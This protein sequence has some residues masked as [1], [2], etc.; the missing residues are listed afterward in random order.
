[1]S[2]ALMLGCSGNSASPVAPSVP[3]SASGPS[4]PSLPLSLDGRVSEAPP[5]SPTGIQ[6]ATVTLRDGANVVKTA[7]ASELGFFSIR[8][9]RPGTFTLSASAEGF[10]AVSRPLTLTDNTTAS[11]ELMP[12]PAAISGTFEDDISASDGRCSDGVAAKPCRIIL[13]PI[14][15]PGPLDAGLSWNPSTTATL[16]VTLFQTG[17]PFPLARSTPGDSGSRRVHANLPGGARYELR[18]TFAEGEG[19]TRFKLSVVYQN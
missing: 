6:G 5:T 15:S 14:H 1:M 2:A 19:T 18:V 12:V 13:I 8:G 11:F 16:D 4:A 10:L 9:L 17:S 7:T 3:S